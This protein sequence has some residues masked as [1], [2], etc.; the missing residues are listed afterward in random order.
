MKERHGTPYYIAPEVL[1]GQYNEKCDVWSCG[2]ILYVLLSG[3]VPFD[4]TS[5]HEILGNVSQGLYR[6]SGP[7]WSQVSKEAIDLVQKLLKFNP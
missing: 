2:V 7:V 5:D 6:I 3:N 4:G 1:T